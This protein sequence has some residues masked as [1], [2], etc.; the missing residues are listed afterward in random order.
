MA[1]FGKQYRTNCMLS[2]HL[3]AA[4]KM[5]SI[6]NIYMPAVIRYGVVTIDGGWTE[7]LC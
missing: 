6:H 3:K 5:L 2:S 7:E 4:D 1:A